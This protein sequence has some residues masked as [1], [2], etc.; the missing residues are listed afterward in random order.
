MYQSKAVEAKSGDIYVMYKMLTLQCKRIV[1]IPV[2]ADSE[3]LV[4]TTLYCDNVR[5]GYIFLIIYTF[6]NK[7]CMNLVHSIAI[8]V[9]KREPAIFGFLLFDVSMERLGFA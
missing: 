6:N 5:L 7:V 9:S 3:Y 2:T 1:L 8:I 4:A